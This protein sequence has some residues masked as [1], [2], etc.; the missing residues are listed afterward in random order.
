MLIVLLCEAKSACIGM[1]A[2]ARGLGACPQE[3]F[4]K[5]HI[6]GLF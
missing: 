2:N 5:C 3:N 6:S 4:G 1:L